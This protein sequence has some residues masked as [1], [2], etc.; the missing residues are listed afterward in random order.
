MTID[1][2]H[3]PKLKPCTPGDTGGRMKEAATVRM[4][5]CICVTLY[6]VQNTL[7]YIIYLDCRTNPVRWTGSPISMVRLGKSALQFKGTCSVPHRSEP[8]PSPGFLPQCSSC[9]AARDH[10]PRDPHQVPFC[11]CNHVV[12][13]ARLLLTVV[14][15]WGMLNPSSLLQ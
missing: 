2:T 4:M 8:G 9:S 13:N 3:L 12:K 5:P 7:L 10:L 6:I 11:Y 1:M 14:P 15:D